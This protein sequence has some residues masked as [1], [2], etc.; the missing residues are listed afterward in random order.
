MMLNYGDQLISL[1]NALLATS[2][3]IKLIVGNILLCDK[4]FNNIE[5]AIS[6]N[7]GQI[8]YNYVK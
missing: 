5:N 7:I 6:I 1:R 2:L 4:T 8:E 3:S